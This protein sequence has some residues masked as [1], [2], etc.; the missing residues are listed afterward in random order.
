[1]ID[2]VLK[3]KWIISLFLIFIAA[4]IFIGLGGIEGLFTGLQVYFIFMGVCSVMGGIVSLI[5][6]LVG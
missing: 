5:M 6:I 1:M 3:H 4:P 2:F